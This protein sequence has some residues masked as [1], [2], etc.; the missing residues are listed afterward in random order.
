MARACGVHTKIFAGTQMPRNRIPFQERFWSKV[1]KTENCWL[2]TGAVGKSTGYGLIGV[3][4]KGFG[5]KSYSAHRLSWFL[6]YGPP[7]AT[8]SIC[9]VCDNRICV[10]PSHLFLGTQADNIADAAAKGR[11]PHSEDHH[12]AKLTNQDIPVIRQLLK[13]GAPKS[14]I[15][16]Q[17]GVSVGTIW[18]IHYGNTWKR[19]NS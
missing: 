9:H 15:A 8:A 14:Q 16:S 4:A 1:E 18:H 2:W 19:V 10:R 12:Q 3:T 5:T 11:M 13:Q 7:P 6:E 17:Y